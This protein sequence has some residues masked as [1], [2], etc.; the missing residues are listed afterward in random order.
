[1]IIHNIERM[2]MQ[3]PRPILLAWDYCQGRRKT[4]RTLNAHLV[5][6]PF[7]QI[8]V[9]CLF[10]DVLYLMTHP[11]PLSFQPFGFFPLIISYHPPTFDSR[12]ELEIIWYAEIAETLFRPSL[13][14]LQAY[15]PYNVVFLQ[16]QIQ[17]S[18]SNLSYGFFINM[19]QALMIINLFLLFLFIRIIIYYFYY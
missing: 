18:L 10:Q 6:H 9:Y 13:S 1:M 7:S 15:S 19:W 16:K 12:L 4:A 17:C 5:I 8:L 14:K 2:Q 3:E 11:L